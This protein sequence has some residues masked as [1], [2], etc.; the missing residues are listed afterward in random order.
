M[1]IRADV[2]I[3]TAA[4]VNA[5][6]TIPDLTV[7]TFSGAV[8]GAVC[9]AS[10]TDGTVWQRLLRLGVSLIAGI[11]L[12]PAILS[13]LGIAA[14]SGPAM[15]VAAVTAALSFGLVVAIS[16][17]DGARV[18]GALLTWALPT[19]LAEALGIGKDKQP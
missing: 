13:G 12:N 9:I 5:S 2:A 17:M 14:E 15:T 6:L 11:A 18:L 10:V 8:A 16:K 1:S 4:M 7:A 19:K 3:A